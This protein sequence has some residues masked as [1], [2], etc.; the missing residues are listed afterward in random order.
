MRSLLILL[1]VIF[2]ACSSKEVAQETLPVDKAPYHSPTPSEEV[3]SEPTPSP[4]VMQKVFKIKKV[5]KKKSTHKTNKLP[6][7][8]DPNGF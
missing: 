3:F 8:T 6:L 2:V 1:V 5:N 4:K 7:K